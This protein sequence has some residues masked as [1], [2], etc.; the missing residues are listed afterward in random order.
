[1]FWPPSG[2]IA[3]IYARSDQRGVHVAPANEPVLG[4]IGVAERLTD[5]EQAPLNKAGVNVLRVFSGTAQPIVWGARTTTDPDRNRAWQYISTRRLFVYLEKSIERSIRSAIFAPNNPELWARLRRSIGDF[6]LKTYAD[7]A[8]G[9]L[10]PKDSFYVRIDEA[11]NPESERK[12]GRLY[13]EIGVRPADPAEFIVMRIG[14][15]DGGSSV[16]EVA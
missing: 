6:L 5:R 13:T 8:F 3:G 2:H 15:W 7:G 4:A 1:V 10:T 12:L 14:I 11:L 9:G 16:D